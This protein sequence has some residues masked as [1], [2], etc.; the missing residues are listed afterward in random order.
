MF[1][2]RKIKLEDKEWI[3]QCLRISDFRG[4]EY[5]FANNVAW[6]RLNDTVICHYK[7][8]YISCSYD[9]GQPYVTFPTGVKIDDSGKKE[10]IELFADLKK[11]FSEQNKKLIVSSVNEE[12]L[13]WIKEYYGT[14]VEI[15]YDRDSSDYIYNSADLSELKGKKYHGKRNHIKRFMDNEWSFEK[16][17]SANIN[18]CFE[19]ATQLYNQ[20]ESSNDYSSIVEQYAINTFLMNMDYFGLVGVVLKSEDKIVGFTIGEQLNSDTFIVHIE[21]ALSDV[22]GAYPM[23]CNQFVKNFAKDLKYVNREEDLGIEGLRKSKL[24]YKP[25]FLLDKYVVT[26]N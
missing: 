20:N 21:K 11:Y 13:E 24:S 8:F 23:I 15:S 12:N 10:Y 22:Q 25:V 3:N 7:N 4:G 14:N 2:F 16:I 9:D 6:Q 5:S 1:Q 19:F 17:D 18:E 26:F